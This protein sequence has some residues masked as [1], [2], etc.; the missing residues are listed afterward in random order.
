M[1]LTNPHIRKAIATERLADLRRDAAPRPDATAKTGRMRRFKRS[2]KRTQTA[3][4][5]GVP[6]R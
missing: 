5:A 6:Q 4:A 3:P 1:I 2:A